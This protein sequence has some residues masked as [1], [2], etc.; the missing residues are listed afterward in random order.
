MTKN[1]PNAITLNAQCERIQFE[2]RSLEADILRIQQQLLDAEEGV[3]SRTTESDWYHRA[4]DAK[5]HKERDRRVL[6]A[7]L[8]RLTRKLNRMNPRLRT[9]QAKAQIREVLRVLFSVARASLAFYEED[10][11]ERETALTDALD[12]LDE[13]VPDWDRPQ[14]EPQPKQVYV[15]LGL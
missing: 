15:K 4:Q 10:S 8:Q 2:M 13:S 5:R 6:D 7:R 14:P 9:D 1:F 11:K 3:G 12:R